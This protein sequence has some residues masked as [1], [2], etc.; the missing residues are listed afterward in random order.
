MKTGVLLILFLFLTY[1]ATALAQN[2]SLTPQRPILPRAP[3]LASWTIAY[4]YKSE[5][6]KSPTPPALPGNLIRTR[7]VTKSN[8]IYFEQIVLVFGEKYEKWVVDDAQLKTMPNSPSIILVPPPTVDPSEKD[9]SDYQHSDFP[10]LSWVSLKNY[11]GVAT[12]SGKPQFH[13][14]AEG[15]VG[16]LSV[17]TQLPV[18]SGDDKVECTYVFNPPPAAPLAVPTRFLE[19]LKTHKRAMEAL[20]YHPIPM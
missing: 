19:V 8:K 4:K 14:E 16:F 10:D 17:D 20:K 6:S 7:T 15:K 9:Y 2:S 5:S 13:F 11:T 18:Y 3:A 1:S 12:Y